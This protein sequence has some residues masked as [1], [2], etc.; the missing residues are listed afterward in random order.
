[1]RCEEA[2]K[3]P[4]RKELSAGDSLRGEGRDL[5]HRRRQQIPESVKLQDERVITQIT[6]II[7]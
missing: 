3:H 7:S 6:Q 5:G 1:M 2:S 4:G